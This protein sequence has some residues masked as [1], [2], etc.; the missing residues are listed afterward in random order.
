MGK[1]RTLQ[2]KL[3]TFLCETLMRNNVAALEASTA[4]MCVN[5]EDLL[6]IQFSTVGG[7]MKDLKN[8]ISCQNGGVGAC[9]R[10]GACVRMGACPRQYGIRHILLLGTYF[11]HVEL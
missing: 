10:M 7:Y 11:L 6:T 5:S 9:A 3:R 4:A 2:M 8:S 1:L